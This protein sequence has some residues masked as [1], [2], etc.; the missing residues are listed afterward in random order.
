[1]QLEKILNPR[2]STNDFAAR[3]LAASLRNPE[4]GIHTQVLAK[5][6]NASQDY[7][8]VR[9]VYLDTPENIKLLG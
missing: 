7:Y 5:G 1:M 3:K 2:V 6:L 8:V 9:V 4:K